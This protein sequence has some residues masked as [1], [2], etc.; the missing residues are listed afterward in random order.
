MKYVFLFCC[1]LF[2]T[3]FI[4]AQR[5]FKKKNSKYHELNAEGDRETGLIKNH[6]AEGKWITYYS[7]SHTIK[8]TSIYVHGEANGVTEEF[9]E[10]GELV[11]R[12]YYKDGYADSVWTKFYSNGQVLETRTYLRGELHG[13]YKTY[14]PDGIIYIHYVY[15]HNAMIVFETYDYTG[16]PLAGEYYLNGE[17]NGRCWNTKGWKNPGSLHRNYCD[18]AEG[19]KHGEE[20]GRDIYGTD[21]IATRHWQ[22]GILEGPCK[23]TD[24]N[25]NLLEEGSFVDGY[26]SGYWKSYY[27][28]NHMLLSELWYSTPTSLDSNSRTFYSKRLRATWNQFPDSAKFYGYDGRL[29]SSEWRNKDYSYKVVHYDQDTGKDIVGVVEADQDD[30]PL[31]YAEQMPEFP[32]GEEALKQ[33]LQRTL[34]YPQLASE[35]GIQGTVYVRFTVDRDGAVKN[36][37]LMKSV[38]PILDK[39]AMRVVTM[40]PNWSPGKINGKNVPV[41]FNLP[42]RFSLQ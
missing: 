18:Y 32:G 14:A 36:A 41:V 23:I 29:E 37:E 38:H 28:S 21:N 7:K 27:W 5:T 12:G 11:T 17:K 13:E 30:P 39:E 40:M 16:K 33:Y 9:N 20:S 3:Q 24:E 19:K 26:A 4:S 34:Q 6:L 25:G 35:M 31:T 42:I 2:S 8:S 22:N 15:D 1:F 10:Q